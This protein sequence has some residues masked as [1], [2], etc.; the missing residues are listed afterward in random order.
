MSLSAEMLASLKRLLKAQDIT[1]AQLARRMKVSEG[2][3]KRIFSVEA[4]SLKRLE[5]ICEV[6]NVDLEDLA[7]ESRQQ[8]EPLSE[9]S[10]E[11]EEALL[12]DPKQLLALYLAVNRWSEAEVVA[13]Y[14]LTRTEWVRLLARLDRLG[15]LTLLPGNRVKLRVSRNFRWRSGGP[16]ERLFRRRLIPEFFARGFDGEN[17]SLRLL[18]GMLAPTSVTQLERHIAAFTREFAALLDHDAHLP[19]AQRVGISVVVGMRPWTIPLFDALR[20]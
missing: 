18:T 12:A 17:E 16:V 8:R 10:V 11:Q 19:A 14:K 1:Y 2:T 6:L 3:V 13:K 15:V 5:Q 4:L 20:R 9:L 7:E